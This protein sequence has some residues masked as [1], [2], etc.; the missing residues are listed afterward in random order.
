MPVL[1]TEPAVGYGG[2]V[3]LAFFVHPEPDPDV[4]ASVLRTLWRSTTAWL[5][6]NVPQFLFRLVLFA[7]D[8]SRRQAAD[9]CYCT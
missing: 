1:V 9:I 4:A 5:A 8:R 7:I 3:V 6:S 2:G